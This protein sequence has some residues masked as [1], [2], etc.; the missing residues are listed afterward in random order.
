MGKWNQFFNKSMN[1]VFKSFRAK[2]I[3][4]AIMSLLI[5]MTLMIIVSYNGIQ[6]ISKSSLDGFEQSLNAMTSEYL[7]NYIS[8]SSS[9]M[10]EEIDG[11]IREQAILG[12]LS[13]KIM[14]LEDDFLDVNRQLMSIKYFQDDLSYNGR[15]YQNKSTEPSV[16]LVQRYLIDAQ[17]KIRPEVQ[18]LINQ[19][20]FMD[21]LLPSFKSQGISKQWVYFTGPKDKSFLRV[22]PWVDIGTAIDQVYPEHTDEP[23]W[24]YFNP[25]L[26]DAWERYMAENPMLKKDISKLTIL[27]EPAQDGGTGEMI[28]T[29]RHPLWNLERDKMQGA[30]SYDVSLSTTLSKIEDIRLGSSGFAY[31]IDGYKNVIAIN[32][33][34]MRTLGL[35]KEDITN[36]VTGYN[37][38]NRQLGT[39]E[40]ESVRMINVPDS[41]A[42]AIQEMIIEG[43]SYIIVQKRF[44]SGLSYNQENGIYQNYWSLG[45]VVP[46]NEFYS[47]FHSAEKSVS[48]NT[49]K[50]VVYQMLLALVTMLLMT[51]LIFDFNRGATRDLEKLL[52]VTEEIKNRNYDVEIDIVSN[53]EF[54]QLAVAFRS[55]IAE[56]K[57]TVQQLFEQNQLFKEEIDE[58]KRKER[59]IDY[60]ESYD[61]LTNLPNASVFMRTIDEQVLL[62]KGSGKIGAVIVLG[63]DNFRRVNEV[64]SHKTG[65]AVLKAITERFSHELR[66]VSNTSKLNGD[67]FGIILNHL[68]DIQ[69]LAV[70]IGQIESIFNESFKFE[71][72]ELFLT[73]SIGVST[74]PSDGLNSQLLYKNASSALVNAKTVS[75]SSYK[76]FDNET[77]LEAKE[78]L[79][80]LTDLRHAIEGNEFVLNYQPIVDVKTERWV[81]MEALIRWHSK[82]RGIVP[83]NKFIAVAEEA[84]LI[85][86]ISRWVMK[87]A[88]SDL[89]VMH[90]N[91]FENFRVSVNISPYELKEADFVDDVITLV[92]E[93]DIPPK[94]ISLEITEG[95]FIDNFQSTAE[96]F[97]QLRRFG[98]KISV[99][100]FGTG[101]SS[102][103]YVKKLEVNSLK[104]DQSFIRGIPSTDEGTIANIINNLAKE[105]QLK[106]VAEGVETIEQLNFLKERDVEE[107]QGYYFSVP[108][109]IDK[110]SLKLIDHY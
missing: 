23:N 50:I 49:H 25:G 107:A 86:P 52:D 24:E 92:T 73:V 110:L 60:L 8:T 16:L 21:L 65:D 46:K 4:I 64:Y 91:G 34:G 83:P 18:T 22:A 53:D 78:K 48:E 59:I 109:P 19:T 54:G 88:F 95:V 29:I 57:L 17:N 79:E 84:N 97:K 67:E 36:E 81:G 9:F 43:E 2:T 103:S 82:T 30:I 44:S 27:S 5:A 72:K 33:I 45:V 35:E 31:L 102:L 62:V 56:I 104:I 40:F 41:R 38:L 1:F 15:W 13:Q 101:Y 77:N 66:N 90:R 94:C 6:M 87:K 80:L 61:S 93:M 10:E 7:D 20:L 71:S 96:I 51:A 76:F 11:I 98:V 55:M 108:L 85:R 32:E 69:E 106:V 3:A 28:I 75:G 39:S 26:V 100:D 42:T 14:D 70:A 12:D 105:L 99:D 89:K 74:F 37:R 68:N 47:A 58:R 63:I